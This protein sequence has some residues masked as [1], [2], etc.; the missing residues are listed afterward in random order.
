MKSYLMALILDAAVSLLGLP[1]RC[2]MKSQACPVG[3]L[4]G[5]PRSPCMRGALSNAAEGMKR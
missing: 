3:V 2:T 5:S 1:F 4:V